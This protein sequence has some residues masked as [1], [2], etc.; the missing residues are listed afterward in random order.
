MRPE[1]NS[2]PAGSYVMLS[3]SDAGT[4]MDPETLQH[5]FEPFFTTK[6]VGYGTGLGLATVYGIVKQSGGNICVYSEPGVGTSFKIY[7]PRIDAQADQTTTPVERQLPKGTETIL[8]VE[9][10]PMV[11]NIARETLELYGYTVM[12]ASDG[13]EALTLNGPYGEKIDLLLTDVVMPGMGGRELAER[14]GKSRPETAVL[15]MSGYTDDAIVNHGVLDAGTH[16]LEKPF[17]PEALA[18]KVYEVL[19]QPGGSSGNSA[20]RIQNR[21]KG[22]RLAFEAVAFLL[23]G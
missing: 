14:L 2:V 5:I 22:K 12:E 13:S 6:P 7:L 18:R 1:H 9:D 20:I 4:G 3:V 11:R 16:F 10:E 21:C 17:A 15:Y 8:L 19:H 23:P